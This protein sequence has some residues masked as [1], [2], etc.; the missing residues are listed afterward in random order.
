MISRIVKTLFVGTLLFTAGALGQKNFCGHPN[1][2]DMCN[3][4]GLSRSQMPQ[5]IDDA[6]ARFLESL[7]LGD[8][9]MERIEPHRLTPLQKDINR[10][11][12]FGMVRKHRQGGSNPC[13]FPILVARNQTHDNIIDGHHTRNAC[14]LLA[15]KQ[16]AIVI[17]D[18]ADRVFNDI[19]RFPGVFRIGLN[20][21]RV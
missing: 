18:F 14:W 6:R 21:A 8:V 7:P 11:I 13:D 1:A 3:T 16:L 5:L 9:T 17:R 10:D 19:L 4:S 12:V 15:G 20:G 2:R